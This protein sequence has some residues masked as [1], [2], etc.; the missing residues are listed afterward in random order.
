MKLLEVILLPE[1]FCI[2][3]VL[4]MTILLVRVKY[5][6][7]IYKASL[8]MEELIYGQFSRFRQTSISSIEREKR[9]PFVW[10][11][12]GK[13]TK[14]IML[15]NLAP[16]T[17]TYVLKTESNDFPNSTTVSNGFLSLLLTIL[18]IWQLKWKSKIQPF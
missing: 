17:V 6:H 14:E 3:S 18:T 2:R 4:K 13:V 12:G 5:L 9:T 1:I 15:K 11:L 7:I 10:F 8:Q 16:L